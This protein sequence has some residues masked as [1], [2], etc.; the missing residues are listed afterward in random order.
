MMGFMWTDSAVMAYDESANFDHY[1]VSYLD[2]GV[3]EEIRFDDDDIHN[4]QVCHID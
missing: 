4:R 2:A 3:G 1:Y